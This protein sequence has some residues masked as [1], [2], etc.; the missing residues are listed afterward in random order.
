MQFISFQDTAGVIKAIAN[1]L[2][3]PIT[4]KQVE[5]IKDYCSFDKMKKNSST[6]HSWFKTLGV[7]TDD[8]EFIRKGDFA[9][10][11][12][13][14]F[15]DTQNSDV[16]YLKFEQIGLLLRNT[17]QRIQ[18]EWQIVQTLIRLLL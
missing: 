9:Y 4:E 5:F 17:L 2:N 18:T 13:P 7:C 10:R 3:K 16:I 11:K 14:K 15:L 12:I 1:F 6:N 8:G